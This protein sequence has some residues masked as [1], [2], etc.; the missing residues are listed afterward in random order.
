MLYQN[1]KELGKIIGFQTRI[2]NQ[3]PVVEKFVSLTS[4]SIM[5]STR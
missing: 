4:S 2:K 3:D 1:S 5:T